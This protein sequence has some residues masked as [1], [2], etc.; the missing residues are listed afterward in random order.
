VGTEAVTY[1]WDAA[2]DTLT[3]TGPRGALFTVEVNPTT[4]DYTTTLQ[5]NVLHDPPVDGQAYENNAYVQRLLYTVTDADGDHVNG[6]LN[7]RIND[8]TPVVFDQ[9]TPS[10]VSGI[11][12]SF[13]ADGGHV[14]SIAGVGATNGESTTVVGEYDLQVTGKFGGTLIVD[15]HDSDYIYT[16]PAADS[17]AN[18]VD[19]LFTFTLIDGDGDTVSGQLSM[20]IDDPNHLV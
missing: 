11:L 15:S 19:E 17:A 4:G 12:G 10:P 7:I 5:E 6:T 8:D 3:A 2:T 20:L 1:S 13:G 14:L 9:Q 16:P 18:K